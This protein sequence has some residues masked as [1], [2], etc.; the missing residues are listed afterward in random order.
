MPVAARHVP[1]RTCVACRQQQAKRALVR[2]VRTGEGRVVVDPTGK[3]AGRGAYVC[4]Q[5]RCWQAALR[6][7]GLA[8]ALKTT[9]SAAD[10]AALEAFAT[11]IEEDSPRPAARSSA[12]GD[13]R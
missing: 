4:H 6:K 3:L 8:R 13:A 5:A 10:R 1:E 11:S 7:D 9:I 12:E 2:A